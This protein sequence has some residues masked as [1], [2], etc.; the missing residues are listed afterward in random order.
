M[1]DLQNHTTAS[2]GELSPQ[3]LVDL[4]IENNLNAIAITD[5]DSVA[6][7]KAALDY[8]IDKDIEIIPGIELS[9]DDPLFNYDKIDILGLFIDYENKDLLRAI[10]HINDRREQNKKQVIDKLKELGYDIDY[11]E[12]K[13]TVGGTFGRPHI[14]KFLIKKYPDKFSTVNDV[15]DNLL[16]RGKPA[17]FETKNRIS[18]KDTIKVIGNAGG[19]SIFAH[20]GIY[21]REDS[22]KLIDYFVENGGDGIET[23]YPYHVISPRTMTSSPSIEGNQE[24]IDFYKNIVKNKE[25]LESGGND[26]HGPYRSSIGEIEI[27]DEIL[28]KLKSKLK[29]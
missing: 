9:S 23:Y 4:A 16:G 26:F 18:I 20:P 29:K 6:S 10:K 5:H 24:M 15:F 7:L 12:V 22:V 13:K 28:D 1:I 8:S 27:P 19:L 14:A 2:D 11:D 21:P 17:F 25:I 3:Q